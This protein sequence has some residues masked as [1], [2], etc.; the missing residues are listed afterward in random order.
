M[1]FSLIVCTIKRRDEIA[2]LFDSIAEQCRS[3]CEVILV[4]QNPD[5]RL[6]E[7]CNRF[8]CKFPLQ[9]VRISGTGASRARNVGLDHASGELIG[10]PDD[11]CAYLGGYLDVVSS[12]FDSD[13][14]IDCICGGP[15]S[16]SLES[17]RNWRDGR[18]VLS[19]FAVVNRCIEFTI[20]VRSQ[21]LKHLRF[22]ECLGVG[23][24]TLWGSEE[25]PD[26]L[27]RLV[28]SGCRLVQFPQLL[29]YHPNKSIKITFASLGLTASYSR[30]RGCLLRL[31]GFPRRMVAAALFRSAMGSFYYLARL[32]M[33]RSIYY[34]VVTYG[35]LR[36]LFMSKGELADV[37]ANTS[38]QTSITE[39]R[40]RAPVGSSALSN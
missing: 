21:S 38:Y 13:P 31:H 2:K 20:F 33:M 39:H 6:V 4:D 14:S 40:L 27:I 35:M 16:N 15:T 19:A 8:A 22:N 29:V 37:R 12:I 3:D 30:G 32:D 34:V 17:I 36:G 9:H 28:Q 7:I 23:A 18:Q 5:D 24:T 11:D 10:F 1:R 26:L 25:G